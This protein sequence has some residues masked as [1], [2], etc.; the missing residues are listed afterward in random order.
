MVLVLFLTWASG[1]AAVDISEAIEIGGIKQWIQIKGWND[2]APVLLF[3]HGG[4][5]NSSMAYGGKFTEDLQ[6]YFLVAQWDQRESGKTALLNPSDRPLTV[7]LFVDDAVEVIRYLANRYSLKKIYLV[8][9]SWGS[10]LGLN[11]A[12]RHPELLEAYF[13]MGAMINQEESERRSLQIMKAK[14]KEE[15]NTEELSELAQVQIP[16]G[17]GRQLYYHRKWLNVLMGSK[18]PQKEYVEQWATKWLALFREASAMNMEEIAPMLNCPVYFLMGRRDYQT[19]FALAEAYFQ[20]VKAPQKE[21][22]WFEHSA[23]SPNMTESEK[24]QETII[25]VLRNPNP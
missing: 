11:V 6:K 1:F 21:L 4:P 15:N 24:F 2:R 20:H 10:F 18:P 19:S 5:G 12:A 9:H 13:A 14:A 23:H 22:I 25:K 7:D 17:D 8:G 3:L 16:F